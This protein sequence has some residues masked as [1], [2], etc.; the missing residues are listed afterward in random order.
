MEYA[1]NGAAFEND[2]MERLSGVVERIIYRNEENGYT[3]CDIDVDGENEM[4][5]AVG[6]L[7]YVGVGDS[8]VLWG[9]WIHTPKYGRQFKAE[10]FEKEMPTDTASILRYLSSR[11]IKGIGPRIAQRIVEEFGE[12]SLDVIENHPEW[13]AHVQGISRKSA[14]S[15]SE[16]YKAKS[17]MRSAMM[18]FREYFGAATTVKIYKKWGGAAVDV[19]RK[20]PYRLC[21]EIEG[22]GFERA[23]RFAMSMGAE[24]DGV[25]R[26]MSGILYMLSSNAMS[27]GHV[28]LPRA[29][30]VEGAAALLSVSADKVAEALQILIDSD[31]A[32]LRGEMV[33]DRR[34]DRQE[35]YIA[36]KLILLEKLCAS[37]SIDDVNAFI[38]REERRNSVQYAAGQRKAIFDAL[39]NGVMILTGGPG[40]GKTTV[41]KA[42]LDIFSSMDMRVALCAP[43]GRAA[44]RLSESTTHEAKTIHRLLEMEFGEGEEVGRFRRNEQDLLDEDVIIA[45]EASMIDNSLM[46]ALL[47][48]I[49]PGARVILIG[50]SDQLPSVGAG[51]VLNDIIDSG[52]F[53]TVRLDEIFR[54]SQQS[55]IVTNAH[56]VNEGRYPTLT[57][58]DSDFFFLPR[59]TDA[60]T[61]ATVMQLYS[62]RLPRA[63]GRTTENGIQIITPSRKGECGTDNLNRLLQSSL[64][65]RAKGKREIAFRDTVYREGDRVMQTKN[66]YDV[67]WEQDGFDGEYGSGVFNGDIGVIESIDA[68]EDEIRIRFDDRVA[69]YDTTM[70]D[71]LEH[72]WAITVHK[73]QGSEYPYVIIPLY[74]APPMLLCRNL[75]YT[76]ITRAET[77]VILVG[78]EDVLRRMVDNKRQS[79]RYTG[80][81]ERLSYE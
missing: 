80:L 65:P 71:E 46:C 53:A 17:G 58:K 51:R 81:A 29:K 72:A 50:D 23:D 15:I 22:V 78:K 8:L 57:V 48:A 70:L 12:D 2:G 7:P 34:A 25:E 54:Q 76:A 35:Q 33:Y 69:L 20:N 66:N 67:E 30:L 60:Q 19:A 14:M 27:N 44:K 6:I 43:T 52:R 45:D 63:Y 4:Q 59:E 26:L 16:D 9:A 64:N 24:L 55:L 38:A 39:E 32:R 77:M 21:D 10:R 13:L 42:L 3:V 37:I 56:A 74:S 36:D 18:F 62:E 31:G 41:V 5:T 11:T 73:S 49:K 75:L 79:M 68:A 40:T 61:A 1:E 47:R 28:C